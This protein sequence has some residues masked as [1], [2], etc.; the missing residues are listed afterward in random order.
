MDLIISKDAQKQYK[1][2]PK[3]Y[4][5]KIKKRLMALSQNPSSGKKLEGKLRGRYVI[6]AWP[7]RIIYFINK[8][9]NRLEVSDILHRQGAYK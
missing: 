3:S 8:D 9:E 4:Q 1:R 2:I 6:R 5:Q 7:Y